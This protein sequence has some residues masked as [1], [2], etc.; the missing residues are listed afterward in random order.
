MALFQVQCGSQLLVVSLGVDGALPLEELAEV[1]DK[2]AALP[3]EV[4]E[5]SDEYAS[6]EEVFPWSQTKI[7]V[8][9]VA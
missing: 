5:G 3:Q 9:R 4:G 6:A 8:S 7:Y 2:C 1:Q